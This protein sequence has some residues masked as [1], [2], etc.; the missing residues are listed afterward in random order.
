MKAWCIGSVV[1]A[2]A[3]LLDLGLHGALGVMTRGSVPERRW[4]VER[5]RRGG[6]R[7]GALLQNG[8]GVEIV[9]DLGHFAVML[10]PGQ[11][12]P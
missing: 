12:S 9:W 3:L 6:V 4:P 1:Q 5:M 8:G 11:T 10:A 2:G 7:G